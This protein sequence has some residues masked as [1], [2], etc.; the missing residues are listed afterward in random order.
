VGAA[1]IGIT[2]S[3]R[4]DGRS[5]KLSTPVPSACTLCSFAGA[6][7]HLV[8]HVRAEGNQRIRAARIRSGL[9]IMIHNFDG[10]NAI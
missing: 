4:N 6:V 8:F 3:A 7:R 1:D 5:I 10:R 9:R 2:P